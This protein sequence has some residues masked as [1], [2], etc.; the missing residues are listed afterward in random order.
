MAGTL[1]SHISTYMYSW[2]HYLHIDI[3]VHSLIKAWLGISL[4]KA[5]R[6]LNLLTNA[7]LAIGHRER[8]YQYSSITL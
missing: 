1:H 8:R 3:L 7:G 5:S 6:Y 2:I 4:S